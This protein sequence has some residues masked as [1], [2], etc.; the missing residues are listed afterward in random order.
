VREI[1]TFS[2]YTHDRPTCFAYNFFG[3]FFKNGFGISMKF[4]YEFFDIFFDLTKIE[5]LL[6][7]F[8]NFE[9]K[10]AKNGAKNQ[11]SY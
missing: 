8:S 10:R 3:A 2:T 11:K 1:C 9:A 6:V 4:Y 7:L 5:V